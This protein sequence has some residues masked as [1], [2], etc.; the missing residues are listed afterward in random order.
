MDDTQQPQL[1]ISDTLSL[2]V[3]A[4]VETFAIIARRGRGKTNTSVVLTEEML[5]C[6]QPVAVIDPLGVWW[7]LR[8]GADG[9]PEGGLPILI[10]GGDHGDLPL[11][12]DSG[13][14]LAQRVVAT[15][16]PVILDLSL[17]SK[18]DGR[19]VVTDFLDGI[20]Q[21]NRE[22]LHVV[23]DEADL[24]APQRGGGGAD[25]ARAANAMSDILRRARAR[26]VGATVISQRPAVL[27]KDVLS[28]CEVLITLSMNNPRDIAAIDEWISLHADED[29]AHQLKDSL[30]SLPVGT[31][32]VWSPGWLGILQQVT[33]RRRRTYDS[34]STP[35]PGRELTPLIGLLPVDRKLL[36]GADVTLPPTVDELNRD[37]VRLRQHND[38][39]TTALQEA[40][41]GPLNLG[42]ATAAELR[43][44]LTDATRIHTQLDTWQAT[45]LAAEGVTGWWERNILV[46]LTDAAPEPEPE[47][48]PD[49]VEPEPEPEPA[50]TEPPT[51]EQ[52]RAAYFAAWPQ[53][54]RALTAIARARTTIHLHVANNQLAADTDDPLTAAAATHLPWDNRHLWAAAAT[55]TPGDPTTVT[56]D[57]PSAARFLLNPTTGTRP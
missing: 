21:Y 42:Y 23:I 3:A 48:E 18:N 38:R 39:L 31:G 27:S 54:A 15:R 20:Y 30:P 19:Q 4:V 29:Q 53:I 34:S 17:L 2:P 26:G 56:I 12:A 49:V 46:P 1:H 13:L 57:S 7:G 50:A 16:Q 25:A 36:V 9:H 44:M 11:D 43:G 10:I 52:V 8:A 41:A 37:L 51:P 22:P 5:G 45:T 6:G 40:Q 32:W 14:W 33:I 28:Q 47:P 35:T 55:I 24:Y